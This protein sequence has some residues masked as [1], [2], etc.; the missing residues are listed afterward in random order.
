MRFYEQDFTVELGDDNH[1][2]RVLAVDP[3][4]TIRTQGTSLVNI[5]QFKVVTRIC[6]WRWYCWFLDLSNCWDNRA[7]GYN[8]LHLSSECTVISPLHH[9]NLSM[10]YFVCWPRFESLKSMIWRYS[11]LEFYYCFLSYAYWADA[12]DFSALWSLKYHLV[13]TDINLRSACQVWI[14]RKIALYLNH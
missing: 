12:D 10:D 3:M 4:S 6:S 7:I 9:D 1:W 13:T 8:F 5:C 14:I 11:N 2:L